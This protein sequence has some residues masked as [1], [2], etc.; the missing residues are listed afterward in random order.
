MMVFLWQDVRFGLRVLARQPAFTLVAVLTR[1]LGVGANTAIFSVVNG[2][3]LRSPPYRGAERVMT[4]W[5]NDLRTSKERVAAPANYLDW[6]ECA[7]SFEV[8]A[9]LRHG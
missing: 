3:L 6:R 5:Q 4:H 2:T 9:A 8:M 1:A 7:K